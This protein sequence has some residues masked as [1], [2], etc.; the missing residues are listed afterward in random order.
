L[1][2]PS[3]TTARISIADLSR[4]ALERLA[5]AIGGDEP[6]GDLLE[7]VHPQLVVR[8]SSA[9]ESDAARI[10]VKRDGEKRT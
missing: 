6:R 7:T 4:R 1:I 10:A 5:A 2:R 3:L 8:E 9:L